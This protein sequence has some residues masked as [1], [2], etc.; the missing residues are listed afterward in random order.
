MIY[1][2]VNGL[3][4]AGMTLKIWSVVTNADNVGVVVKR[5]SFSDKVKENVK[6]RKTTVVVRLLYAE[7]QHKQKKD[8]LYNQLDDER[9]VM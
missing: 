8:R 5:F 7:M 3:L 9:E 6:K 1:N 2:R 4:N